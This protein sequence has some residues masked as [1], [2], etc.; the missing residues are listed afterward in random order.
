MMPH[1]SV[2]IAL[3]STPGRPE[4]CARKLK[5]QG[6]RKHD[7]TALTLVDVVHFQGPALE[8]RDTVQ[9]PALGDDNGGRG[10]LSVT[11]GALG[12]RRCPQAD[13]GESHGAAHLEQESAEIE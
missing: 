7:C 4:M 11:L 9:Q 2:Q 6:A 3:S 1:G 5:T 10:C 8:C 13:L 12:R